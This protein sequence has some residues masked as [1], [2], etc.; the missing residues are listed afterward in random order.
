[1]SDGE[2][3]IRRFGREDIRRYATVNPYCF[4]ENRSEED[5]AS[6]HTR[7]IDDEYL[8]NA[9]NQEANRA[10][11]A[12]LGDWHTM[13]VR[14]VEYP[15]EGILDDPEATMPEAPPPVLPERAVLS[16]PEGGFDIAH[17]IPLIGRAVQ[18]DDAAAAALANAPIPPLANAF[19]N[20]PAVAD[21]LPPY[22][23]TVRSPGIYR[24]QLI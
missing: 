9:D 11:D 10:L 1:M 18:R 16:V 23:A 17:D 6:S 8:A 4:E 20:Q 2:E 13:R 12:L 3:E 7:F 5:E 19:A 21:G 24:I 15:S 22:M 14:R